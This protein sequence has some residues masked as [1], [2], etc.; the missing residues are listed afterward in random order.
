MKT[1]TNDENVFI[2]TKADKILYKPYP[3]EEISS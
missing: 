3:D 1:L 2:P